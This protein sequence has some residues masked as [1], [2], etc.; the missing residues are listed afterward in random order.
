MEHAF[1]TKTVKDIEENLFQMIGEDW[2]LITAGDP[3]TEKYNTMTASWGGTG[4][5]WGKPVAF[6]FIRP[7]RYTYTFTEAGNHLT[8]SFF[9]GKKRDAL[10]LCGSRSGRDCDKIT[11]AGLT[12]VIEQPY[13]V[14]LQR[15]WKKLRGNESV[16]SV[17]FYYYY[18]FVF[19]EMR[20][21][22]LHFKL[23]IES[24]RFLAILAMES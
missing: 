6:C 1:V 2:M 22:I 18:I 7:Q 16:P 15:C 11:L 24:I 17:T 10:K 12:P 20:K 13:V 23:Y 5:L 14:K 9:H 4:I 3:K 21:M 19:C 8:L